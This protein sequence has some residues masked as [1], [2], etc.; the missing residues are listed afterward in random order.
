VELSALATAYV[1]YRRVEADLEAGGD[2]ELDEGVQV[3][4]R[5]SF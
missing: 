3:G 5:I 1:G 2:H 4:V